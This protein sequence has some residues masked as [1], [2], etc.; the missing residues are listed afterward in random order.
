MFNTGLRSKCS[1]FVFW[2]RLW[3]AFATAHLGID[4]LLHRVRTRHGQHGRLHVARTLFDSRRGGRGVWRHMPNEVNS[5]RREQELDVV[6]SW[7]HRFPKEEKSEKNVAHARLE[8]F[9]VVSWRTSI[10]LID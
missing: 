9:A 1:L 10:C 6:G 2:R 4:L 8:F 5:N 7:F 3:S